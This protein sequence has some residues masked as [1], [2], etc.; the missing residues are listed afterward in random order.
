M[1][2][3]QDS[4]GGLDSVVRIP[5]RLGA[6]PRLHD[7]EPL[8]QF[9]AKFWDRNMADEEREWRNTQLAIGGELRD[10]DQDGDTCI[11]EAGDDEM[12]EGNEA[13]LDDDI[14]PG[15]YMLDIG[16]EGLP[17]SSIWIRSDYVRVYDHLNFHYNKP[18]PHGRAP[19]VVLTGQPGVGGSLS[20]RFIGLLLT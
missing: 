7:Y 11:G 10:K 6:W 12:D 16:I 13:D 19:A 3:S 2:L 8:S 20:R 18:A 4:R 14:I 15:C 9:H 17:Y 1:S 5:D